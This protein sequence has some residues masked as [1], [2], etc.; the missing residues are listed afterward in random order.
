MKPKHS[1][2]R[3]R[4]WIGVLCLGVVGALAATSLWG[5]TGR[6]TAQSKSTIRQPASALNAFAGSW[7]SRGR[8]HES[9][10][11]HAGTV[12]GKTTCQWM[13]EKTYLACE[14]TSHQPDG[15]HH[16]LTVYTADPKTGQFDFYTFG[17]PGVAP[18]AGQLSLD[19]KLW[20]YGAR[21]APPGKFPRFRTTNTFISGDR[22]TFRAEYTSDGTH[23]TVMSE[24]VSLRQVAAPHR[25]H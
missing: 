3:Q 12:S 1:G 7:E 4:P 15:V 23:W 10:Y 2:M 11:T 19:G 14:Q 5:G 25:K 18:Y 17:A 16:Q 20:T 9:P 22:Y 24:G 21:N 13:A 6:R 8:I